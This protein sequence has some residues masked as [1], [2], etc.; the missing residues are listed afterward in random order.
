MIKA[1]VLAF[2]VLALQPAVVLPRLNLR[3]DNVL[4]GHQGPRSRAHY[5]YVG[6]KAIALLVAG[7]LLL[8]S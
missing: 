7:I 2:A 4:A 1:F 8:S 6:L 3:A 5:A